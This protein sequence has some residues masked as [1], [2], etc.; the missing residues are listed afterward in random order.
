[1]FEF[2][3]HDRYPPVERLA[4]HEE[5]MHK[6]TFSQGHE[7]EA[8]SKNQDTT[9]TAWMKCNRDDPAARCIK[10]PDF[11]Q[12]YRWDKS[13]KKWFKRKKYTPSVGRVFSTSPAQ[14]ERHYL[15][16]LLYHRAG[17]TCWTDLKTVNGVVL[18]T[19]KQTCHAL[20]I[21]QDDK[22]HELC[23][24]ESAAK[25]MPAQLRSLFSI[26][27]VYCEPADPVN[28]WNQGYITSKFC[29]TCA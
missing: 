2:K 19:F 27:L 21:L 17:A 15:R 16:M 24:E 20:G 11:P 29:L 8:L 7:K 12:T 1:M 25:D 5:N 26:I 22:E 14:G 18:S 4:I 28:L 23:L 6:V 10:Y 9:L 3:T 13:K